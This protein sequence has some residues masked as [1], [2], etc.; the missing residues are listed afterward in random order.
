MLE[1]KQKC[2]MKNL[3]VFSM[4]AL[5]VILFIDIIVMITIGCGSSLLGF[6]NEFYESTYCVIAKIV[7]FTSF[8]AYLFLLVNLNS[9]TKKIAL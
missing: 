5:P 8:V 1:L 2:I 9:K 4:F 3:M 6:T 7:L